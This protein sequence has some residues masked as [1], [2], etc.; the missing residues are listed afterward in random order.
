MYVLT[1]MCA[2]DKWS[3]IR[4]RY[5]RKDKSSSAWAWRRRETKRDTTRVIEQG[6]HAHELLAQGRRGACTHLKLTPELSRS[7]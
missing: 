3:L 6:C 7:Y 4:P 2:R 5:E 1:G